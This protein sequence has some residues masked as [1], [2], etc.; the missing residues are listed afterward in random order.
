MHRISC[1]RQDRPAERNS[2]GF[3]RSRSV[4]QIRPRIYAMWATD[5]RHAGFPGPQKDRAKKLIYIDI[6]V[7]SLPT[8]RLSAKFLFLF[9]GNHDYM[10][11]VPSRSEG[12]F[13]VVTDVEA[14]CGGRVDVAAW[15]YPRRRTA[16]CARSSRVVLIPRRWYHPRNARKR[17]VAVRWPKSPAHQGE[18]EAAVPTIARGMPGVFG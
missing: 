13:A 8:G 11:A 16:R 14:G 4:G 15:V 18:R 1:G 17:V 3:F 7:G 6:S 2:R 10:H 5:R 12:R 9:S